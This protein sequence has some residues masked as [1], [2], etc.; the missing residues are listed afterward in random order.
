MLILFLLVALFL[1][2]MGVMSSL[3]LD[4]SQQA[5]AE[6]RLRQIEEAFYANLDRIDA[7]HRA[8]EA[9]TESLARLAESFRRQHDIYPA[10]YSQAL[11]TGLLEAVRG[12]PEAFGG[13]IWFEPGA[14]VGA[15]P[16]F[17]AYGYWS[18]GRVNLV[19][20][21][22][23][24]DYRS[25]SWYQKALPLEWDRAQPRP[26][27]F[28]WTDAYFNH[29]LDE[30]VMTLATFIHDSDHRI[31]GLATTD[32]SADEIIGLVSKV[33]VT[34][35]SFAFLIDG[36]DR[37]LSNLSLEESPE[38]QNLLGALSIDSLD[39]AVPALELTEL[40]E[41]KTPMQSQQFN[42]DHRDYRLFYAP[43]RAG[44]V[45]GISVP[46]DEIDS[47]LGQMRDANYK[48]FAVTIMVV[49]L[50]AGLILYGVAKIMRMLEE[51]YTDHLTGLPNRAKLLQDLKARHH[52]CLILLNIDRF[53]EINDF[54][55]HQCGDHIMLR[56]SEVIREHLVEI[57][58]CGNGELYKMPADEFAILFHDDLGQARLERCLRGLAVFVSGM[59][60]QWADQEIS[61]NVTLGAARIEDEPEASSGAA[62]LSS[63]DIALRQARRH[64]RSFMLYDPSMKVREEYRQNLLW[65]GR[66]KEAIQ[67]DRIVPY[68]QPIMNNHNGRIEKFECLVR[69]LDE[70]GNPV[71]PAQFLDVAK[72]LRLYHDIT[73]IMVEK[74]FQTFLE[75]DYS[76]SI[77]L[78]YEDLVRSETTAFIIRR[79]RETSIGPR[80]VFEILES[81]GIAN[82]QQVKGFIEEV[83]AFGCK[84]HIDDFGTGYSNFEHLLRLNADMIKIDGSLI[85]NIDSD[86]SAFAIARG[87]TRFARDLNLGV[88]AEFVRSPEVYEKVVALGID[89]SQGGYVG[90]P[91]PDLRRTPA[92]LDE[93]TDNR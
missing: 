87:M 70:K 21:T 49:V 78:A 89:F 9:Q 20:R 67:D 38:A 2:G 42:V 39:T 50:L 15:V 12:F 69:M 76:F 90:M 63:A 30:V 56:L 34:P 5:L 92:F 3:N 22:G 85:R 19:N 51:L 17:A 33:D 81:E 64:G 66:L 62:F 83:Q 53:K 88:V 45:F 59:T 13:G 10:D 91:S 47:V 57:D 84:V 65:A 73:R 6:L 71:S 11:E 54:Y 35:S 43:T 72:K 31:I 29:L 27:N 75:S 86:D 24:D 25:A 26:Q 61:I 80:V 44:M 48:I 74:T 23:Q 93:H 60:F 28:Y 79:L 4:Y 16:D 68:F 32:W 55:G 7:H 52:H 40:G 58:S 1:A 41:F 37:K 77:N 18:R 14:F 36:M 46:Q 82:Y 8:M